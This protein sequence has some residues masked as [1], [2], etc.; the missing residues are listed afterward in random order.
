MNLKRAVLNCG[1]RERIGTKRYLA[2][3]VLSVLVLN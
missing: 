1:R 2:A 3:R